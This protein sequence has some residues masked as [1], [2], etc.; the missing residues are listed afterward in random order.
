MSS[1]PKAA[2]DTMGLRLFPGV[3]VAI[4]PLQSAQLMTL[5]ATR[6]LV[7]EMETLNA[8]VAIG[9]TSTRSQVEVC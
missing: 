9:L 7:P 6:I 5:R 8:E 3:T 1:A 4:L 2:T